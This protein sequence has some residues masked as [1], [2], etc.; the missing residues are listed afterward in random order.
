[1]SQGVVFVLLLLPVT[2][3]AE[4]VGFLTSL[5]RSGPKLGLAA[6]VH[7]CACTLLACLVLAEA[8]HM[9]TKWPKI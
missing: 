4:M 8:S 6:E 2:R 5:S 7:R 9:A 3:L 1:M